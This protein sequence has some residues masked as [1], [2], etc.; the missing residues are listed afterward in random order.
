MTKNEPPFYGQG[1]QPYGGYPP[2]GQYAPQG[3]YPNGPYPP[4]AQYGQGQ[5]G[6]SQYPSGPYPQQQQ[7]SYYNHVN[8]SNANPQDRPSNTPN[9]SSPPPVPPH[10]N[11]TEEE[12]GVMG[13]LAGGAA[14]AYAGH[15][16]GHGFMGA[17]GG[18][19]AG[20][21][22]EDA[23]KHHH[24]QQKHDEQKPVSPNPQYG[25][26][27]GPPPPYHQQG[28]HHQPPQQ[29]RGNFSGSSEQISLDGDHDLIARCRAIDGSEKLSAISLNKVLGNDNGRFVWVD[30]G[31][32]FAA[33]ARNIRLVDNGRIVEAE[34]KSISGDWHWSRA[35]LDERIGNNNGNLVFV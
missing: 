15:K 11:S 10:P 35:W 18:A 1:Q 3:Q 8:D 21:K 19:F 17:A 13:A 7:P 26:Y 5:Y 22:L 6:E 24:Q 27:G 34:L 30:D 23:W 29:M 9:P 12:R 31:G 2:Q 33:S 28:P 32:N 16:M 25:Q 4:Q 20:H 14:G